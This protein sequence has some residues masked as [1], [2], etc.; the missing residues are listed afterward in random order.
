[1]SKIEN[2]CWPNFDRQNKKHPY[3]NLILLYLTTF[4]QSLLLLSKNARSLCY[5]ARLQVVM[6]DLKVTSIII[7]NLIT[8]Q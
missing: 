2:S 4:V 3:Q 6:P 7:E 8:V 5:A 1:M